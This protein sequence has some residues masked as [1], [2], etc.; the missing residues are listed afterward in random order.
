MKSALA[1][2]GKNDL[3]QI[4]DEDGQ[5]EL[6]CNFC[7]TKYRFDRKELEEIYEKM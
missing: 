3:R 6:C 2:I 7:N 5:A 1:T 4:I